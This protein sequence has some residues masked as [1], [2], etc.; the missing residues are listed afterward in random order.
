MVPVAGVAGVVSVVVAE[1]E[2]LVVVVCCAGLCCC[3]AAGPAKR[4][5]LTQRDRKRRRSRWVAL[6]GTPLGHSTV[7]QTR[8][9][10]LE[11][12]GGGMVMSMSHSP[13]LMAR[14]LSVVQATHPAFLSSARAAAS[15][16]E[17]ASLPV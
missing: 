2:G 12:C 3:D 14:M 1:V 7:G 11:E 6:T 9:L 5:R 15:L 8:T 17:A 16:S 13:S 4:A 10:A